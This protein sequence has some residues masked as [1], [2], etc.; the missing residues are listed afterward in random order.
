MY[1]LVEA[2]GKTGVLAG[3][4]TTIGLEPAKALYSM[5]K[6]NP[7]FGEVNIYSTEV[8]G[9]LIDKRERIYV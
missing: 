9:G 8:T 1:Y 7:E 6:E 5:L 4:R 3:Q 2:Y